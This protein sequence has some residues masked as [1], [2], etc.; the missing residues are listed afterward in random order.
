MFNVKK[1][2]DMFPLYRLYPNLVYL[3]NS[4][5]SLTPQIVMDKMNEYYSQYGVNIHR[6]VYS[7]SH[8]ATEEYDKARKTIAGFIN[9]DPSELVFTKN[10]SNALNMIA[11]MYGDKYIN[12]GD[13]IVTS[14]L[15]HHS[16]FLPWLKLSQRKGAV[17]RFVPLNRD[18]R[19]TAENFRKVMD[20]KVRV[21]ALTYVSNV[22]GYI[23]P[24]KEIISLTHRNNAVV[25]VDAAQAAAHIKID[26]NDLD[27]DFLVFSA[28]KMLGPT[29]I[30]ALYGR[31]RILETLDPLEYGGDMN[32]SV[33]KDEVTFKDAP[34]RFETGTPPI[35]EAL[36]FARAVEYVNSIGLKDIARHGQMLHQYAIDRLAGLP[37]LKLYNPGAEIPIISFNIEGVHPHDAATVFDENNI[38]LR[39]GHHCAQLVS[40][41][42]ECMGTLRASFYIYNDYRDVDK[43]VETVKEAVNF[44]RKVSGEHY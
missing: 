29:G 35:A 25:I 31:K 42:L 21:V 17:L 12:E 7:L 5:T 24:I 41:W 14:E 3:D 23:T 38:C 26:V 8:R 32:A 22:M 6:G 19:I 2:R 36:G 18:G 30:G 10:A 11:L 15:E 33:S 13:V 28:H 9:C 4:A 39:A 27:C 34:F 37:G 16:S 1:I 40:K 43:F 44:F 20:E